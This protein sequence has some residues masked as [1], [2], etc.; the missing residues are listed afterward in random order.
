MALADGYAVVGSTTPS[1][2]RRDIWLLRTDE[3][4]D[5]LWTRTYGGPDLDGA[6][7][8]IACPDGGF[9]LAGFTRSFSGEPGVRRDAW[10]VRTDAQGETL[11]TRAY[12]GYHGTGALSASVRLLPDNGFLLSGTDA[13]LDGQGWLLQT[14][15]LGA[16][17]WQGAWGDITYQNWDHLVCAEPTDDGGCI[18]FGL[19]YTYSTPS[20][21]AWMLRVDSLVNVGVEEEEVR[22]QKSEQRGPTVMRA[23]QLARFTGRVLDIQGRDVTA[24]KDR[25]EP[26]VYFL[27]DKPGIRAPARKVLVAR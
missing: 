26:G 19:S 3:D 7:G 14:D 24:R 12:P 5:T 6:S 2:G 13:A 22:R 20:F 10:L 16:V 15:S 11:W 18:A 17:V 8:I 4:G 27:R 9:A 21:D 1:I 25:L 23:P